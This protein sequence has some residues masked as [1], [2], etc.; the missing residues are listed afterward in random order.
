MYSS[1]ICVNLCCPVFI[2][3]LLLFELLNTGPS[4]LILSYLNIFRRFSSLFLNIYIFFSSRVSRVTLDHGGR[5][6][7]VDPLVIGGHE[8]QLACLELPVTQYV[9]LLTILTFYTGS[10]WFSECI[11]GCYPEIRSVVNTS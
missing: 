4:C 8:L 6:D 10:Q 1:L 9:Q 2:L 7:P 5:L 11:F 3:T